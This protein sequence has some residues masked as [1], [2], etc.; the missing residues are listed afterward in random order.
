VELKKGNL[1]VQRSTN[2]FSLI[3]KDQSHQQSN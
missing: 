1:V 3:V 2:N